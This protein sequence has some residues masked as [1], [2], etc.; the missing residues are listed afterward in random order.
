MNIKDKYWG[1]TGMSPIKILEMI[2]NIRK[3]LNT[4]A[5]N[6]PLFD[7]EVVQLSQILDSFLNS[8]HN[9]LSKSL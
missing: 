8:Y 5:Q 4:L 6:K 2:E 7:P 9:T 3:Q 1:E